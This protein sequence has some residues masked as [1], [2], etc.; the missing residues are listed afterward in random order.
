VIYRRKWRVNHNRKIFTTYG[1]LSGLAKNPVYPHTITTEA[2][3]C[4]DCHANRKAIG[5]GTGIYDSLANGIDID[6]ELERIVNENG[7]QIQATNH[8]GA[9][10][11]N[12]EEQ[13]RI[14]R[15]N[16]CMSCHKYNADA[17][18]WK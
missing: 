6:F 5:P 1:G 12:K 16:T 2:R 17:E 14:L 18:F 4:E 9:R 13:E 10:P 7:K 3:T 15:V 8:Y 11:F